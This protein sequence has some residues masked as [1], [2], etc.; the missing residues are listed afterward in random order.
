MN[1]ENN[2]LHYYKNS[3]FDSEN[4]AIDISRIKNIYYQNSSDLSSP[5]LSG[6]QTTELVDLEE[7]RINRL[8]GITK[9]DNANWFEI[10]DTEILIAPFYLEYQTD[11]PKYKKRIYPFWIKARVDR[12]G[13]LTTP[14]ELFP[15]IVR[16]YLAPI[17]DVKND[18]IFSSIDAVTSARDIE[19]P[20]VEHED[21]TIGWDAYWNYVSEVFYE[22]TLKNLYNYKTEKYKTNYSLT[23]FSVSSKIATAKSILFIYENLLDTPEDL[24]LLSKLITP[25]DRFRKPPV[26]DEG[27]LFYNHLHLGQMSNQ[28]PLSI[29]QRKTLLSYLTSEENPVM[30]VNGPPG[31]GKTTLLQSLVATEV[32]KAAINGED[33]P[34]IVACSNNNQAVTNIIDSFINSTSTL[35]DLAERWIPDFNGYA[36]Y[37][38]SSSKG[39]K[40]LKNINYLKGN[41]F[42]HEGTL[43]ELENE[44]YLHDAEY[45]FL[46]K[47]NE[48]YN[49]DEHSL[50]EACMHLQEEIIAI[51]DKLIDSVRFS[52]D[53]ISCINSL[54]KILVNTEDHIEKTTF[55]ITK[56]HKWRTV[57]NELKAAYKETSFIDKVAKVFTSEST[58]ENTAHL[59]KTDA[60]ILN[61]KETLFSFI[62][63]QLANINLLLQANLKLKNWKQENSIKGYPFVSE[64][65][66]WNY[67]YEKMQNN[68]KSHRFF[69]DEIDVTLRHEAFLLAIHYWEARWILATFDTLESD[70]EKGTGEKPIGAKWK[71]RAML[72]PCFVGTFYTA[73]SHFVYSQ[74]QGESEQGKPIFEYL[75]LYNFI[76]LLIIDEAGQVTP[77]VSIPLFA[78]AQK[79]FVVGDLKQIEPI[80][81]IPPKIDMGNLTVLDIIEEPDEYDYLSNL[82]FLASSGSIMRMTQNACEYETTINETT[83]SGLILLEHRR[84]N[85]EIIGFCNELA[86]GGI[87]KPMK[88][89]ASEDQIFPSMLAYHI[90]GV[91]ERKYNSRCNL[92]EVKAIILWLQQ[93]KEAIQKNY[94]VTSVEEILGI[95]TPFASQ[96]SELAKALTDAGFKVNN[97][98]LGTV[99]AL[100]GAE[101]NIILFSSVYSKQDE[102]TLFFDRDNKPNMLNVAVSRAKDSFILFGDTRVFDETQNTPSGLLKKHLNIQTMMN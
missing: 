90:E 25:E 51:E 6:K 55:E 61:N 45:Y 85:D 49:L 29:S 81:S 102:G 28:F 43:C 98:K 101:R 17:A 76:D 18:F 80:W 30:A 69:F 14:K 87:L 66:M 44:N 37:L 47:Y 5:N 8:R 72:T 74:F 23:Y 21:E 48:Y 26:T 68:D 36:T 83:E 35:S 39:E 16:N 65:Q 41:L 32:V 20:T 64:E 63:Q 27:F 10:T 53:F 46:E 57:L 1:N 79:A 13:Q 40:S 71:R 84:C 15:L 4:L 91:S 78:L 96:K 89:K 60:E 75:P 100:Q 67:E 97:I 92:N 86:Y 62:K 22:I 34:V 70:V 33:A 19:V 58:S 94:N 56:L 3:L 95:I 38:P 82:G 59:F 7:R 54:N 24:P 2:W 9:K 77:E 52:N 12:E 93:N 88:G 42:G 50:E 11:N 73:P 99:H 31:T